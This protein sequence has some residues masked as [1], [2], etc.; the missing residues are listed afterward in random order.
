MEEAEE[1]DMACGDLGNGLGRRPGGVYE[2]EKLQNYPFRSKKVSVKAYNTLSSIKGVEEID[3]TPLPC[4]KRNT[5][6]DGSSKKPLSSSTR[7]SSC[8]KANLEFPVH[9]EKNSWI[10]C[11]NTALKE[12]L[13]LRTEEVK[14][15]KS[16]NA[17]KTP[18]ALPLNVL[19]FWN[20][21]GVN[22]E[23]K[24]LSGRVSCYWQLML[25]D[26]QQPTLKRVVVFV[27]LV[28][29]SPEKEENKK[30]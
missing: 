16:E 6:H 8:G 14:T 17:S 27:I 24:F 9:Q 19:L 23:Q 10:Y 1:D 13:K 29:L 2:G 15:L 26:M 22:Y 20:N 25:A 5:F 28:A 18:A 11:E 3:A 12:A 7:Q 30:N 4:S 21:S